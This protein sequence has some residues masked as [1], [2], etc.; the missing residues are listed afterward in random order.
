[1]HVRRLR[2]QICKSA[3]TCGSARGHVKGGVAKF[4]AMYRNEN[5]SAL[6]G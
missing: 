3:L 6:T 1:M 4:V 2:A 5:Q